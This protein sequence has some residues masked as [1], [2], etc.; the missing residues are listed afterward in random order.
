M[1]KSD[2]QPMKLPQN[3]PINIKLDQKPTQK[4]E[5]NNLQNQNPSN[6]GNPINQQPYPVQ[7]TLP[8]LNQFQPLYVNIVNT[9]FGTKPVSINC[10]F[11]KAPVT[12]LV[13]KSF[14]ICSCLLC[15][16]TSFL[17]WACCQI[18]RKKELNCCDAKHTCPNCGQ[19]LGYY[20]S[21]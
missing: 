5:I 8:T 21:C 17:L 15:W 13:N 19:I 2:V 20:T 18:V 3:L 9:Q 1:N 12:T 6:Y 16:F 7:N 14:N 11:C 10:Q 4:L